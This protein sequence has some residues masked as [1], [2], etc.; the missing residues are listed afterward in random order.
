MAKQ[1]GFKI[2]AIARAL[3]GVMFCFGLVLA[4]SDGDWFPWPNFVGVGMLVLMAW[5]AKKV[6]G[7]Y[8]KG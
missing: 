2:K 4:G 1:Y 8:I 3:P 5:W 7:V 6:K